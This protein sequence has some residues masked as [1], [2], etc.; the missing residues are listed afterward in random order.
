MAVKMSPLSKG[1]EVDSPL[2]KRK[3]DCG[4]APICGVRMDVAQAYAGIPG[5]RQKVIND[6]D[7]AAWND[8]ISKIDY[9]VANLDH[10]FYVPTGFGSLEAVRIPN[11]E[12]TDDPGKIFT[13]HFHGGLEVW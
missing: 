1:A 3:L 6:D 10:S 5:L 4:G 7:A 8:I 12:E 11:V 13:A 9:M 2:G